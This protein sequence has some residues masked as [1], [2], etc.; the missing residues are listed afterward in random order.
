[1]T[2]YIDETIDD[3]CIFIKSNKELF[4]YIFIYLIIKNILLYYYDDIY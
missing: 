2:D 1:M 4:I 3:I